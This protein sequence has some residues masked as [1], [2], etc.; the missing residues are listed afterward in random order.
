MK[1]N[2]NVYENLDWQKLTKNVLKD[3][4]TVIMQAIPKDVKTILDIGCG[5]G[6]ITNELAKLYQVTGLDRSR[7][8]LSFVK[9]E[10]IQ[11]SSDNIPLPDRS[12][13][14]IFSSELMEH[15]PEEVFIK[16]INEMKRLTKKYILITVPFAENIKKAYLK[17]PEC[18]FIFNRSYHLRGFDINSLKNYF[19]EYQMI[20]CEK[21][22]KKVRY[23]N[24]VL[25]TIKHRFSSSASWIPFYWTP[26]DSRNSMCP[27]CECKFT[28]FYR[29]NFLAFMCDMINVII[30][31][32]RPYWLIELFEKDTGV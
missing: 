17:C 8:A 10:N 6:V 15:L 32:K 12:F 11:S 22:G 5:N 1:D 9:T 26:K 13:D 14:L 30:S 18:G 23:Y 20:Y 28:Y 7:K 2:K 21:T 4:I 19:P 16:T 29:F 31:P 3:K 25:A 24:S 27:Q